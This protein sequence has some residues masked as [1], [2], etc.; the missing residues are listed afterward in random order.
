MRSFGELGRVGIEGTGSYGAGLTRHLAKA[1]I[2]ILEIDGPDRSDRRPRGKDD[3][4]DAINAAKAALHQHRT[5][6]RSS[7][8]R[9]V[10][11]D[12]ARL[13]TEARVRF[14]PSR[15]QA[16]RGEPCAARLRSQRVGVPEK[17]T[18]LLFLKMAE[19][20]ATL[21]LTRSGS[22]RGVL[23]ARA[24][25][26]VFAR[27]WKTQP[28]PAWRRCPAK[29]AGTGR[30]APVQWCSAAS[31]RTRSPNE[32]TTS[33]STTSDHENQAAADVE[34]PTSWTTGSLGSGQRAVY[35]MRTAW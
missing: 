35:R 6:S 10:G 5:P 18:Y 32:L 28:H 23:L 3:D 13:K 29:A 4:L 12:L 17:L 1:G 2:T 11:S 9:H 19:E 16:H 24:T 7:R 30:V 27:R 8:H 14:T 20:R 15:R 31:A 33:T 26:T 25:R 21:A 22:C 34:P